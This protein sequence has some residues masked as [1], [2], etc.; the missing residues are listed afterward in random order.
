[1]QL[2]ILQGFPPRHWTWQPECKVTPHT[3]H[4]FQ[5][6]LRCSA[7]RCPLRNTEHFSSSTA[8]TIQ[9]CRISVFAGFLTEQIWSNWWCFPLHS[10][11]YRFECRPEDYPDWASLS[12]S[13]PQN[14]AVVS[15]NRPRSFPPNSFPSSSKSSIRSQHLILHNRCSWYSVLN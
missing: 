11:G 15:R 4:F 8:D 7:V 12:Q 9:V 10:R 1:M 6:L 14:A 13:L 2:V 5:F 3:T